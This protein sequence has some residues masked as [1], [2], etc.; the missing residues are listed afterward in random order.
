M[1]T[2]NRVFLSKLNEDHINHY[3]SLSADPELVATMDWKPFC[4]DEKDRFLQTAEMLSVPYCKNGK[5]ITFSIISA[6]DK[7]AIGFTFY[8]NLNDSSL[9]RFT[10]LSTTL[11]S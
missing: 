5:A 2:E 8:S 7:K 1:E 6:V 9:R 11:A 3:I 4:N 10:Q